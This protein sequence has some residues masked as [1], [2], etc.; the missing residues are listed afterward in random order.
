MPESNHSKSQVI[1]IGGGIIGSALSYFLSLQ[2]ISTVLLEKEFIGSGASGLSAGTLWCPFY[3]DA[4][5]DD[6]CAN[7]SKTTLCAGSTTIVQNI[8]ALHDVDYQQNSLI[9]PATTFFDKL[10]IAGSY[11]YGRLCGHDVEW[12]TNEQMKS[13]FPSLHSCAALRY[14]RSGQVDGSL[15]TNAFASLAEK[16]SCQ[17][18]EQVRLNSVS[19]RT[20]SSSF[21]VHTSK[22]VFEANHVVLATGIQIECAKLFNVDHPPILAVK[23]QIYMSSLVENHIEPVI[24][25]IKSKVN[26]L[27]KK[28]FLTHDDDNNHLFSHF[29]SKIANGHRY[30]GGLRQKTDVNDFNID[31]SEIANSM[32]QSSQF[33]KDPGEY[34][35]AWT[36]LMPFTANDTICVKEIGDR[37]WIANGFGSMGMMCGPMATKILASQIADRIARS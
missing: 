36:G 9:Y 13:S 20:D 8:Q 24:Y 33:F 19:H 3:H 11:V 7:F 21:C 10:L 37:V 34:A 31:S 27:L 17:V 4:T 16:Q 25:S 23:G 22:G 2:N 29:Y 35:G 6:T 32:K 12:I 14:P 18:V 26:Q 28:T 30:V 5:I 1:V 15:L